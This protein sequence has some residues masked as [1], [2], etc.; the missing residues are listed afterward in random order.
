MEKNWVVV[1]VHG[2]AT[3]L[4]MSGLSKVKLVGTLDNGNRTGSIVDHIVANTAHN[5]PA[6]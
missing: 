1:V 2:A 3:L 5:H 4:Y 6:N